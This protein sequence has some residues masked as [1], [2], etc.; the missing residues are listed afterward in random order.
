MGFL[1]Y[2]IY[3]LYSIPFALTLCECFCL[4]NGMGMGEGDEIIFSFGTLADYNLFLLYFIIS[5]SFLKGDI[6]LIGRQ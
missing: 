5:L 6:K 4:W 1:G 2:M 3:I